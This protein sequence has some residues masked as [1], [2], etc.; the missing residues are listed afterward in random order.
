VAD[1]LSKSNK[2]GRPE[3]EVPQEPDIEVKYT[4]TTH[5][6]GDFSQTYSVKG[7]VNQ[8]Q[9]ASNQALNSHTKVVTRRQET[10]QIGWQESSETSGDEAFDISFDE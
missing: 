4:E 10:P 3:R 6:N 2:A 9:R 8:L 7:P 1:Y 5:R